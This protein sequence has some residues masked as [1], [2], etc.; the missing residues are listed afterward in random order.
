L[1]RALLDLHAA[2]LAR[3]LELASQAGEP[4]RDLV[5]RLGQD[6]LVS[7]LLVLHGLH[8]VPLAERVAG[9]LDRVRPRLRAWGA[10]VELV[11]AAGEVVRARLRGNPSDGPALRAAV[12]EAILEAAPDVQLLSL[13]EAWDRPSSGRVP[14]PLLAGKEV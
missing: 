7:N 1:V 4:G 5:A 8:P 12:E 6:G 11:E 13:E 3:V 14:L 9:A 2:G 10:D